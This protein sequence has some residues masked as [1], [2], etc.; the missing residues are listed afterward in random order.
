M[1]KDY[2]NQKFMCFIMARLLKFQRWVT[3]YI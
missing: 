2:I 1:Q 3:I